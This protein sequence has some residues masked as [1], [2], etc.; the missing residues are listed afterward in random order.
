MPESAATTKNTPGR[1]TKAIKQQF[2]SNKKFA[3]VVIRC[4]EYLARAQGMMKAPLINAANV[5][6]SGG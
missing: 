3:A 1:W 6:G 5:T 2:S 4:G